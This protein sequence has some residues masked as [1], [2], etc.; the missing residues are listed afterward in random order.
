MKIL[1]VFVLL[2]SNV[3]FGQQPNSD[4]SI[5]QT[6]GRDVDY[7][8]LLT[9]KV[10][11]NKKRYLNENKRIKVYNSEG[12]HASGKLDILSPDTVLV[13]AHKIAFSEITRIH[14]YSRFFRTT[15]FI[16]GGLSGAINLC[17]VAFGYP[18]ASLMVLPV[19]GAFLSLTLISRRYDI[20]D[21]YNVY[22]FK[23]D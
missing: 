18:E 7:G 2:S 19:T 12:A 8:L 13:G 3:V 14:V 15:G 5:Q 9:K 11:T 6:Q 17:L 4:T 21:K 20:I 23:L 16:L 1:I 22:F 10:D